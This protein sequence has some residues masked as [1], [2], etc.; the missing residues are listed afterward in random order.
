MANKNCLEGMACPECG[1]EGPFQ[2]VATALMEVH[3]DG[4]EGP[5]SS[6]GQGYQWTSGSFCRCAACEHEA[7]VGDFGG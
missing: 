5:A 3:D 7:T 2:I 4:V 1:S 6:F